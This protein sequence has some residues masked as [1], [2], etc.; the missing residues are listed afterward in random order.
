MIYYRQYL[1]KKVL[2]I[3][4]DVLTMTDSLKLNGTYRLVVTLAF[5][6]Y[7]AISFDLKSPAVMLAIFA[8]MSH[9]LKFLHPLKVST[10]ANM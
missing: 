4:Q 8:S 5:I 7:Y 6:I 3:K 9:R 10:P 1:S 2:N